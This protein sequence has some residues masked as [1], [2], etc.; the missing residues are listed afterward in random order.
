MIEIYSRKET[1]KFIESKEKFVYVDDG[2]AE[3]IIPRKDIPDFIVY[4]N[5]EVQMVDLKFYDLEHDPSL[6]ITTMGEFL[7][8]CASDVRPEIID[9]L[10]KLQTNEE[11]YKKVKAFDEGIFEEIQIELEDEEEL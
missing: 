11:K 6:I 8:K 4:V 1:E 7:D 9:R 10:V 3:I 5:R 2:I